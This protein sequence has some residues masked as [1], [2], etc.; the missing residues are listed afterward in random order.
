MEVVN[1]S[2]LQSLEEYSNTRKKQI[3]E[4]IDSIHCQGDVYYVSNLGDDTND[5]KMPLTAWKT[6][7]KVSSMPL[8]KGACVL[9]RRGD[10]FRGNVKAQA[11]ITY[12][13]YGEGEK[14]KFY[15]WKQNLANKNLWEE[16]DTTHHI[17]K[18]VE[19]IPDC[20]TLVFNDGEKHSRKL[21]P[22]YIFSSTALVALTV[23]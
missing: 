6:L 18:Y 16:V 22:S 5:G 21:I 1:Q 14:P 9:F 4:S 3:L 20:G 15:G 23:R 12:A 17:W 7:K 2:F 10:L 11:G 8:K 13:A 19:T